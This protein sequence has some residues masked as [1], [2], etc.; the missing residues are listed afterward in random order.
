[1]DKIIGM[2]VTG[3]SLG[4][5]IGFYFGFIRGKF[6][7]TILNPIHCDLLAIKPLHKAYSLIRYSKIIGID[8]SQITP[9]TNI[10]KLTSLKCSLL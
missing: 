5:S 3:V 1:M 9:K 10:C 6:Q 4:F 7:N 8:C 2:F